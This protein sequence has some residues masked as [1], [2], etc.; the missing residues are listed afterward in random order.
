MYCFSV[1]YI[2]RLSAFT[3]CIIKTEKNT[4]HNISSKVLQRHYQGNLEHP[5]NEISQGEK[6][7]KIILQILLSSLNN[8]GYPRLLIFSTNK[9]KGRAQTHKHSHF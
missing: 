2:H 3:N 6:R 4:L 9:E 5:P 8:M 1:T 7:R